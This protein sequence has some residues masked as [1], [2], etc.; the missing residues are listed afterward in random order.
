MAVGSGRA[1]LVCALAAAGVAACANQG[2]PPGGQQDLRPPVVVRTEP[3]PFAV[4]TE[5][6]TRIRFHFDERVSE[7]VNAGSLDEA[8]TVSPQ[9]GEVRVRHG[10]RSITIEVE[11]GLRPGVVYRV[12]LLPVVRDLFGNQLGDPFELV[13]STGG[14][15]SPTTLAGQVW[16]RTTGRGL[17]GALVHAQGRD[18]LVHVAASD[19]EGIFALRYLPAGALVVTAF[20]DTDRDRAPDA[21]EVSGSVLVEL[22]VGDTALVDVPVLAPDTTAAEVVRATPLDSLTFTLEFDDFLDPD[23]A[24]GDVDVTITLEGT[25]GPAVARLFHEHEYEAWADSVRDS[26]AAAAPAPEP[27]APV[28]VPT[29]ADA[30]A[31]PAGPDGGPAPADPVVGPA[32]VPQVAP[33][34]RAAQPGPPTLGAASGAPRR[35]PGGVLIPSRRFVARLEEPVARGVSYDVDVR[36]AVNIHGLEGGGGQTALE[37][38]A[39]PSEPPVPADGAAPSDGTPPDASPNDS[40]AAGADAR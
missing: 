25:A 1:A 11:G 7:S 20:E 13:F 37:L 40:A 16:D 29:P 38:P 39:A 12:T 5:P 2:A 36:G 14:E 21:R 23:A 17:G 8:V 19:Q 3:A 31:V 6:D 26:L 15:P 35:G 34:P 32:P 28:A 24:A 27:A 18:S 10:S 30:P 9:A 33:A 4:V 22:A